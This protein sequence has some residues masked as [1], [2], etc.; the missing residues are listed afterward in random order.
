[1]NPSPQ[2]EFGNPV[3]PRPSTPN[4]LIGFARQA[5]DQIDCWL[6]PLFD[7]CLR[8]YVGWQFLKSG[9][10]KLSDW[11]STLVLF[12][13]EYHVPVVSPQVAAIMGTGGELLLPLLLCLGLAA[14]FGA[15]G[16]FVVNAMA[17]I[18]YPELSELG[19]ADHV[20]WGCLLLVT[21]FHGPGR[22]SL[23]H[24]LQPLWRR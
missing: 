2:A 8:F 4:R 22:W 7:L 16:L 5:I 11:E 1:M 21:I 15:A 13:N 12:E 6:A 10:L 23:D 18:A 24:W 17:V 20:L 3:H 19:L 9:W 14:R